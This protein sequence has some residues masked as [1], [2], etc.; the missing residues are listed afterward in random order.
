[1]TLVATV[2]AAII[3]IGILL[4]VFK[5]NMSNDLVKAVHDAAKFLAGPFDGMF[6]LDSRKW[7]IALNW[8][9]AAA[10]Y[11]VVGSLIARLL[12]R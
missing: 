2:V 9:I 1:M 11:L 3:V 12:R 7:T 4:V 10:V 8:G 6:H 5:A